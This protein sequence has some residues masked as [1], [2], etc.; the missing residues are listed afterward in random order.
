MMEVPKI[1]KNKIEDQ[2]EN[3]NSN[4]QNPKDYLPPILLFTIKM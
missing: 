1:I 4:S 3:S 2:T